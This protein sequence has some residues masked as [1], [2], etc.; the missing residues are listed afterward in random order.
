M[1]N[2]FS[3]CINFKLSAFYKVMMSHEHNLLKRAVLN[4]SYRQGLYHT[5]DKI[6]DKT[7]NFQADIHSKVIYPS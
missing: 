2:I 7:F 6:Y 5:S 4:A 3:F 1:E